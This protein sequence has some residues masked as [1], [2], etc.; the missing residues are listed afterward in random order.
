[1]GTSKNVP[2]ASLAMEMY[3]RFLNRSLLITAG[4]KVAWV[5]A[6]SVKGVVKMGDGLL[7]HAPRTLLTRVGLV[8]LGRGSVNWA[9]GI[10][11]PG[12]CASCTVG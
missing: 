11:G 12:G 8:G 1:M 3:D 7:S 10:L 9:D 4:G 2:P 6:K 5:I